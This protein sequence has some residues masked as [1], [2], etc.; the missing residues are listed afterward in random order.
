[1]HMRC[2]EKPPWLSQPLTSITAV[3]PVSDV[4]KQPTSPTVMIILD[5]LLSL[6]LLVFIQALKGK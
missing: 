2:S 5:C 6:K 1:M 4:K 3:D